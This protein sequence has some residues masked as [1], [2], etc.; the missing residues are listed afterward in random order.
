MSVISKIA[1]EAKG[2]LLDGIGAS[3]HIDSSGEVLDVK[4]CDIK[5]VQDGVAV[6]NYEHK[7]ETPTDVIGRLV[8]AKKI[9]S[10]DD[11]EDERQLAYWKK[12]GV[13]YIY[14]VGELMDQDGHQGA[15]DAA[16]IVRHYHSRGLPIV[17]RWSIEGSTL[18]KDK[19]SGRLKRSIFKRIA[20]TLKPCNKDAT[21]GVLFDP[22]DGKKPTKFSLKSI[23][24]KVDKFEHPSY[25]KLGGAVEIEC[26]PWV[27]KSEASPETLKEKV[28]SV[29]KSWDGKGDLKSFV[30]SQI[31]EISDEFLDKFAEAAELYQVKVKK[32]EQLEDTIYKLVKK[33][34]EATEGKKEAA[35]IDFQGKKVKPGQALLNLRGGGEPPAGLDPGMTGVQKIALL[36]HD[37]DEQNFLAVH[38]DKLDGWTD[39][40]L[41]KLPVSHAGLRI[42]SYPEDVN[43]P[44]VVDASVHGVH[45][46]PAAA[47][48]V[49]GID[50][51]PRKATSKKHLGTSKQAYWTKNA[52]GKHVF[53]KPEVE[54]GP[55]GDTMREL[56]FHNVANEVLGLGHYLPTVAAVRHPRSGELHSVIEAVPG[57]HSE[58]RSFTSALPSNQAHINT[59]NKLGDSGELDKLGLMDALFHNDDRHHENYLFTPDGSIKLIDHGNAFGAWGGQ[60]IENE[61]HYLEKY[62]KLKQAQGS[63]PQ[64][65]LPFHPNTA[66]W[67]MSINPVALKRSLRKNGAPLATATEAVRKLTAMQQHLAQNPQSIKFDVYNAPTGVRKAPPAPAPVLPGTK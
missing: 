1:K 44:P 55:F 23:V 27:T 11:C 48:L 4:G 62:D 17:A 57:E 28:K 16:A 36:A 65:D 13:P 31:P 5:D 18:D 66:T 45:L 12:S 7:D 52:E 64:E 46:T 22:L 37:P 24:D 49:H 6:I 43:M 40:D 14:I 25:T 60:G 29:I 26:M 58:A 21:S 53:V 39:K 54:G 3:E 63:K 8:Y 61:P 20:L 15:Q 2:M 19:G 32:F 42:S 67:L 33:V 34:E 41:M 10:A 35:P 56:A 50:L 9:Y 38:Q 30:K 47:K 51:D 59:L